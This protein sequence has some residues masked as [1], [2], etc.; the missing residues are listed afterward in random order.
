ME[1]T[2]QK[3]YRANGKLLLTGEYLVL[4][5]AKALATPLKSGQTMKVSHRE[6]GLKWTAKTANGIWLKAG[7]DQE[8]HITE[9]NDIV[10]GQKLENILQQ[11]LKLDALAIEQLNQSEV[12]TSLE[13]DR[14]WGWGSS[15]TLITLVSQLTGV[16][17]YQLLENTFGGSGYDIACAQSNSP[18]V[19]QIK[20]GQP[21]IQPLNFSPTFSDHIYF[22]FSGNKQNSQKEVVRFNKEVNIS[23]QTITAINDI[24]DDIIKVPNI[25]LFG[26]LISEHENIIAELIEQ[27][28]LKEKYFNDFEGYTKSLGAWG[29]DFFMAATPHDKKYVTQYFGHKG[30]NTIYSFSDIVLNA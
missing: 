15:S 10:L 21:H 7:F 8:L 9:A 17:P 27:K 5:G 24:T 2:L 26:E 18:L 20:D 1:T 13:F 11:T 30:L 3:T 22:I 14:N 23:T 4:K 28:T 6:N 29:G 16:N 25:Q 19:Y 12:I